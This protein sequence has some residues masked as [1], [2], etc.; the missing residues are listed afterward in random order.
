MVAGSSWST[1]GNL[2]SAANFPKPKG[3][4]SVWFST[5][6]FQNYCDADTID[7]IDFSP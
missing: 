5:Y 7:L 1:A 4:A 3:A 2:D 6:V